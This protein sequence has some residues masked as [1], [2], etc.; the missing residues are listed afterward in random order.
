MPQAIETEIPQPTREV[1]TLKEAAG[2]LRVSEADVVELVTR[3]ELPGRKIGDQWRFLKQGLADWLLGPS[4]K[5]RL[6]RH[7]G[8]MK[9]DP[10]LDGMLEKIYENRGRSMIEG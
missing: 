9:G 1:L 3:Q 10:D 2:Y 4:P 6:L 5:E 7:A 8:R